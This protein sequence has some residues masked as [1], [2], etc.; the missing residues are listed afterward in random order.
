M[1]RSICLCMLGQV[2]FSYKVVQAG[3][4]PIIVNWGRGKSNL[5]VHFL[6]LIWILFFYFGCVWSGMNKLM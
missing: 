1:A 3:Y 6:F 5:D 2:H 4:F